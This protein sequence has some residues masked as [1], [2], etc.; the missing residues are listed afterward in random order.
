MRLS[1]STLACPTAS[2]AEI[3]A[4]ARAFGFGGVGLRAVGGELDLL[5]LPEFA[6][7]ARPLTRRR[8]ADA[9][10]APEMLLTSLRLAN[11]RSADLQAARAMID[12]AHDL[13]APFIRVFGGPIPAGMALTDAQDRVATGLRTLAEDA[14]GAGVTVLLETHDD[15]TDTRRVAEVMRRADHSGVGLLWDIHHPYRLAGERVGE[16]WQRIGSWVR[17]CDVKDSRPDPSHRLGYR[18]ELL[19][20]GTVPLAEAFALLKAA[21]FTGPLSFEWEKLWHPELADAALALPDAAQKMRALWSVEIPAFGDDL[22]VA[23]MTKQDGTI[24]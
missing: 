23:R 20:S 3:L 13:G 15:F 2:L 21:D 5:K 16:T 24:S 18:Y 6:P 14:V 8:F 7:T 4:F 11:A 22:H 12:L 1:F 19:G 10:V 9:G 17:A